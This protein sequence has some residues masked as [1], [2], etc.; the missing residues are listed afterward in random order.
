MLG[1]DASNL[2]QVVLRTGTN[3]FFPRELY[4]PSFLFSFLISSHPDSKSQ[5][6]QVSNQDSITKFTT[7]FQITICTHHITYY[8]N[9]IHLIKF[10]QRHNNQD[11]QEV[12]VTKT[13]SNL[14]RHAL[15]TTPRRP[16]ALRHPRRPGR[17]P[18]QRR[19]VLA[20]AET[21]RTFAN[22]NP[23]LCTSEIVPRSSYHVQSLSQVAQIHTIL[24]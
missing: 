16:P 21:N 8:N 6:L 13:T 3:V 14:L 18:A 1:I 19:A 22:E 9:L 20:P 24:K 15:P 7:S 4:F 12:T 5:I 17:L 2:Y 10:S 11:S 23:T